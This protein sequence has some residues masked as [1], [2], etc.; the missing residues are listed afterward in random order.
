MESNLEAL[1][2]DLI[3]R[4]KKLKSAISDSADQKSN[5]ENMRAKELEEIETAIKEALDRI[6]RSEGGE[7][8]YFGREGKGR[9]EDAEK[10]DLDQDNDSD[11]KEVDY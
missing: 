8:V 5:L 2:E 11:D 3:A 10:I 9:E 6:S 4:R 7:N 1:S